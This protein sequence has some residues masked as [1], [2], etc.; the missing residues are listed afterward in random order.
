MLSKYM[1]TLVLRWSLLVLIVGYG[2]ILVL[3]LV[4]DR[5][6]STNLIRLTPD[7]NWSP[8]VGISRLFDPL[9]VLIPLS[10][11]I[12]LICSIDQI[13]NT[14]GS[15]NHTGAESAI[16]AGTI[17]GILACT[18]IPAGGFGAIFYGTIFSCFVILFVMSIEHDSDHLEKYYK[19]FLVHITAS[20]VIWLGMTAIS[21]S[22][23]GIL[24]ALATLIMA[25]VVHFGVLGIIL[26][27][28]FFGSKFVAIMIPE[29]E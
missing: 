23:A 7:C 13:Q 4:Q 18:V 20:L 25:T 9:V 19:S 1:R 11:L 26:F 12:V 14:Y 6:P 27:G 2:S 24:Y 10:I 29:H 28:R 5:M 17:F 21:G 8:A 15:K 22:L 16:Y 3:Y